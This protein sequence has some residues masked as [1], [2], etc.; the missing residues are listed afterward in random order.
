LDLFLS[1]FNGLFEKMAAVYC[2][3]LD[4]LLKRRLI[5]IAVVLAL[6]FGSFSLLPRLG[7]EF[8][9][10]Q[11]QNELVVA[12][13]LDSGLNLAA[14]SNINNEMLAIIKKNPEV[15]KTLS[16]VTTDQI[17]YYVQLVDKSKRKRTVWQIASAVRND[18]Q[19]LPGV[20]SSVSTGSS[21]GG[22]GSKTVVF[23]LM[24]DNRD[25]LQSLAVTAQ[26]I[27]SS[28]PGAVD[29]GSSYRPGQPEVQLQV[30]QDAASDLG[31]SVNEVGTIMN[32]LLTGA[33]VGHYD[34]GDDRYD[35]R[36]RLGEGD[37]KDINDLNGIYIPS[38]NNSNMI[39]LSQVTQMVFGS[40]PSSLEKFDKEDTIEISCNLD[41][42]A[43]GDFNSAFLKKVAQE[44]PLPAGYQFFAGGTSEMMSEGFGSLGQALILGILFMFFVLAAQFESFIDPLAVILSLPLAM[45]GAILGLLVGGSHVSMMSFIG[46][47]MLV[48]LVAKNAI[49]LIDFAKSELR[50]GTGRTEALLRATRTRFRPIM[51][52]S[53]V[54]VLSMFPTALALGQGAELRAPMAQAIIGG[55][56]TSTLLTL[57]IVPIIY[58]ILDDIRMLFSR[59]PV[60]NSKE[61]LAL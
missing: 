46:I 39:P 33:V 4:R 8:I 45:I 35:V 18:L 10:Q 9:P 29:V 31:V 41:G 13:N 27:M 20:Q 61:T 17:S 58:T 28:I 42:V 55:M 52:T 24:G 26:R 11:D 57:I 53:L 59:K 14:A 34:D 51:M 23:D 44:M 21:G 25:Q 56:I 2:S 37:R 15:V 19:Q 47:I 32:T 7:T 30:K 60:T 48:G 54:M 36:V 40:S 22:G 43:Q 1:W 3:L 12:G 50:K 6:L 49:L 38:Q 16:T 5:T